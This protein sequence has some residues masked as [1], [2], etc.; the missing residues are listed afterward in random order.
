MIKLTYNGFQIEVDSV[1]EAKELMEKEVRSVSGS[2]LD[3]PITYIKKHSTHI[4][5]SE[6]EM[7]RILRLV[8]DEVP[9]NKICNDSMLR[10]RHTISGI[11]TRLRVIN[12]IRNGGK[13]SYSIS[14]KSLKMIQAY[15]KP[16]VK[17]ETT[18]APMATASKWW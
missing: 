2:V 16:E 8:G 1:K 10:Q 13:K 5:W 9:D 17:I 12:S 14:K 11:V 15:F 3:T 7:D 4:L 18:G 6:Y